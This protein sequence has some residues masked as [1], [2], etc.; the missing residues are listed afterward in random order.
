MGRLLASVLILASSLAFADGERMP[1][2]VDAG[3][4]QANLDR[5]DLVVLDVRSGIDNGGDRSSFQEAHI[6]GSVYSS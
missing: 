1:P 4:L 5:E 3:W 2:L 6:P